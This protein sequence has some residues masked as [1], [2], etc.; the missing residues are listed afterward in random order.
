M[1]SPCKGFDSYIIELHPYR[2]RV[3]QGPACCIVC[4]FAIVSTHTCNRFDSKRRRLITEISR[5]GVMLEKSR[6]LPTA[7][8]SV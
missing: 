6:G 7:L 5:Y 3:L 1:P 2:F 8:P 4:E